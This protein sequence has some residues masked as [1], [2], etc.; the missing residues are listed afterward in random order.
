MIDSQEVY[1]IRVLKKF[2][3]SFFFIKKFWVIQLRLLNNKN[4]FYSIQSRL[5]DFFKKF[6]IK[7]FMFN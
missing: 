7:N 3:K 6:N 4:K 5:L 1:S 2:K